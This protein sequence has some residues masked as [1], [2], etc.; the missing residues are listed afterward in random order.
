KSLQLAGGA[1]GGLLQL[2]ARAN[3]FVLIVS[4]ISA[5]IG[6]LNFFG[7]RVNAGIDEVTTLRDVAIAVFNLLKKAFFDAADAITRFFEPA[8]R[9]IQERLG[10]IP[11]TLGD[12]L[13]GFR[14]FA[15]A[16]IG[17][18]VGIGEVVAFGFG[19]IRTSLEDFLGEDLIFFFTQSGRAIIDFWADVFGKVVGIVQKALGFIGIE[20]KSLADGLGAAFD[21]VLPD[22]VADGFRG[23]GEEAGDIFVNALQRDYIGE[24]G[25]FLL[26]AIEAVSAEAA[27]VAQQRL[28]DEADRLL[29]DTQTAKPQTDRPF[30][31]TKELQTLIDG[32]RTP[33]EKL[34][35]DLASINEFRALEGI[36]TDAAALE[37]LV[38]ADEAAVREFAEAVGGVDP[39]PFAEVENAIRLIEDQLMGVNN[40]VESRIL[41]QALD[42]MNDELVDLKLNALGLSDLETIMQNAIPPAERYRQVV[43]K[44]NI[45]LADNPEAL[46][47]AIQEAKEKI[48]GLENVFEKFAESAAESLQNTLADFLFDPF[49]DGVKGM[50]R[51]FAESIR[52]MAAEVLAN[53]ILQSFFNNFA[54]GSGPLGQF[55]N[56]ALGALGGAQFGA[57]ANAGVPMTVGESGGKPELF[58]PQTSGR[59]MTSQQASQAMSPNVTVQP[60]PVIIVDDPKKAIAAMHSREGQDATV[61]AIRGNSEAVKRDLGVA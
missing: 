44:L 38:R 59:V 46:A 45:L 54:G 61:T 36:A 5:A 48:L 19:Q 24:I 47:A 35:D 2:L 32:L 7:D 56:L 1:V 17:I 34:R 30:E 42:N 23:F 53:Q 13:T 14:R 9:F 8:I 11:L 60:A 50:I 12:V 31:R 6:A 27:R 20:S 58:I 15:N 26:P 51:S 10:D 22:S 55:A 57:Q 16:S 33:V 4:G 52:R 25:A 3:P 43:E 40:Q 28:Q 21:F 18:F 49:E 41:E 29:I 37:S 39:S